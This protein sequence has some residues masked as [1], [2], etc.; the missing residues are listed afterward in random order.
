MHEPWRSS[1]KTEKKENP[2]ETIQ[3]LKNLIAPKIR[4][5]SKWLL[6]ADN[7][8]ELNAIRS[9]LPQTASTEWG[10]GQVLI[11]T[12]DSSTIRHNTSHTYYESLSKGMEVEDAV[13]LL[14]QVSQISDEAEQVGNVAKV[15]EYQPL[16]LAAAAFY[17]QTV[18]MNGSPDY[19]WA[20]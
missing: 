20:R 12:Q 16:A 4:K 9:F 3:H 2:R 7:V 13:K 19:S 1:F 6:I 14:K 18:V 10:H 8:V 15:L 5:F 17:V 11:T